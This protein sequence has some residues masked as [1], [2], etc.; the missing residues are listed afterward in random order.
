MMT[1]KLKH[2]KLAWT[3]AVVYAEMILY[4]FAILIITGPTR[5]FNP[6]IPDLA[7]FLAVNI[8]YLFGLVRGNRLQGYMDE[9]HVKLKKVVGDGH[10]FAAWLWSMERGT[11]R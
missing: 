6:N 2:T 5:L 10:I 8:V 11:G 4:G 9:Y 7:A 3:V 1:K